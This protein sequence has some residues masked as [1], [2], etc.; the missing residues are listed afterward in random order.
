VV[1]VADLP[2]RIRALGLEDITVEGNCPLLRFYHVKRDGTDVFMF[3]NEDS[4]HTAHATV[5]LPVS[6][7]FARLRLIEDGIYGDT[8]PDGRVAMD[9]LPGQ[10]E[11]LV[12]GNDTEGMAISAFRT[13]TA[14]CKETVLAPTYEIQLADSEDLTA[15]YPYK[16]ADR[17]F[18]ITSMGENPHFSG[19][20]RYTFTLELNEIPQNA[21]LDLGRVGQTAKV[22]VNG[23]EVGIRIA[24]PYTYP[25]SY[26]LQKGTNTITVEVANT[27]VGKVRDGFSYH[28]P[29]LPSGLL[30]PVKLVEY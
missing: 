19:L 14:P 15:F 20:I 11:I 27:L 2:A 23:T 17:L 8:T 12:F 10:S 16:T 9:L 22:S 26:L 18:S 1:A 3:F 25:I 21:V 28:M 4:A 30:G 29:L 24:A 13:L 6:G 5:T 7:N